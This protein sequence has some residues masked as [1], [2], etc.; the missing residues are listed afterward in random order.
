[1][2]TPAE[3]VGVEGISAVLAAGV[4]AAASSFTVDSLLD[5]D[6]FPDSAFQVKIGNEIILVG[7]RS[8][9]TFSGLT[10]AQED[11]SALQHAAGDGVFYVL[12]GGVLATPSGGSLPPGGETGQVLQ[13]LS[14]TDGDADWEDKGVFT[15]PVNMNDGAAVSGSPGRS[16]DVLRTYAAGLP[17]TLQIDFDSGASA[18]FHSVAQDSSGDSVTI[19]LVDPGPNNPTTTSAASGSDVTVTLATNGGG[20]ITTQ[21]SDIGTAISSDPDSATLVELD[22]YSD[23]L[24]NATAQTPLANGQD[25]LFAW[26]VAKNGQEA[27]G[28]SAEPADFDVAANT[29][30]QYY[31]PTSGAAK[32]RIKQADADGTITKR[33]SAV[34]TEDATAFAGVDKP[35]VDTAD[36]PSILAALVVLGLVIDGT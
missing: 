23:G 7:S 24:T 26:W 28:A 10:R 17:A 15:A 21:V 6:A 29:R 27:F 18:T 36:A 31:D 11:T 19:T 32:L 22:S 25:P 4:S 16:E 3:E 35:T 9:M 12:G 13:K 5:A 14:G 2:S 30:F 33:I 1:M 8:G 34:L 20:D